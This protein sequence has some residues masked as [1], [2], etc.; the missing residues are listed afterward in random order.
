MVSVHTCVFACV[1][2]SNSVQN[3]G[4]SRIVL[5]IVLTT[6]GLRIF[7]FLG[8]KRSTVRFSQL[9]VSIFTCF[10]RARV[11]R[12]QRLQQ[13]PLRH[14]QRPPVCVDCVHGCVC[15]C[16]SVCVYVCACECVG[17]CV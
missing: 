9:S 6:V 11:K 13:Q 8:P 12:R 16:A 10:F 15:V 5:H 1:G 3:Q 7:M 17:V 14:L 2:C 4:V